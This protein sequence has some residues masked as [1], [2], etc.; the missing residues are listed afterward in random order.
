LGACGPQLGLGGIKYANG[1]MIPA[2]AGRANAVIVKKY[3]IDTR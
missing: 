3:I 2:K 1:E